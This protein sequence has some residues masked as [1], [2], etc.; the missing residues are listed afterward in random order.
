MDADDRMSDICSQY[1]A[2][3]ADDRTSLNMALCDGLEIKTRVQ[4][5]S[6]ELGS[7]HA[8]SSEIYAPRVGAWVPM[9]PE[10]FERVLKGEI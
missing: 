9:N 6:S 10:N 8:C 1:R 4:M 7:F 3:D 5:I 2:M